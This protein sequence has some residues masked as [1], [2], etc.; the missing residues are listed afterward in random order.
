MHSVHASEYFRPDGFLRPCSSLRRSWGSY[1]RVLAS[2]STL[3]SGTGFFPGALFETRHLI[4]SPSGKRIDQVARAV[5]GFRWLPQLT[6][7]TL[8]QVLGNTHASL[9]LCFIH[10]PSLLQSFHRDVES[11]LCGCPAG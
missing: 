8:L 2:C 7:G 4:F 3:D 5:E 10:A 9:E 6:A 11:L 1:M